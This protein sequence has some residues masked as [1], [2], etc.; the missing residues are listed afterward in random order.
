MIFDPNNTSHI[1]SYHSIP[2]CAFYLPAILPSASDTTR[3]PISQLA[4]H[5]GNVLEAEAFSTVTK[6]ESYLARIHL[7]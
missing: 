2:N 3:H 6:H 1:F 4:A 5:M 7:Q